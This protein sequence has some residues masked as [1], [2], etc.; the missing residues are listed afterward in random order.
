M[1]TKRKIIGTFV[2]RVNIKKVVNKKTLMMIPFGLLLMGNQKCEQPQESVRELRRRVEM[3]SVQAQDIYLPDGRKFDF[4]F[5]ANAQMY[6]VLRK[7]QSFS[8]ATM[9]GTYKLEEMTDNDRNA[10]NRC[11]DDILNPSEVGQQKMQS[12]VGAI[13]VV[14]T[15]MINQPQAVIKGNILNFELVTKAGLNIN[16]F[17]PISAGINVDYSKAVLAMS[18]TAEDPFIAGHVL[19][20]TTSSANRVE[21]S[22]GAKINFGEF[23]LGPSAYFKSELS[24]VVNK[25]MQSGI[26]NLK[27]QMDQN[28]QWY[29]TVL[30]NCDK[31]ILINAGDSSDAGLQKGDVLEVYN[32]KYQW[33]GEVCNSNLMGS[34]PVRSLDDKPIAVVQV[35][36]VGN[37]ISEAKI[38]EQDSSGT[39]IQP[40]SRV[41]VK[42]LISAGAKN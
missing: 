15:C 33:E 7:T 11:D 20:A 13:S 25:A 23:G 2:E 24:Q 17:N 32:V 1:K 41:Y 40:G 29:A 31:A 34:V 36:S 35:S 18:Y 22:I 3:G 26:E 4:K 39:K 16:L 5:V 38:I 9:D 30:R 8:T 12:K 37:T 10:F 27:S 28:S 19:A 6:D 14:A 21:T 42:K